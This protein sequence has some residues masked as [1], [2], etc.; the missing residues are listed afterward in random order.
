LKPKVWFPEHA[1]S[2][3]IAKWT[4]NLATRTDKEKY[5]CKYYESSSAE[6]PCRRL[7][8]FN[9]LR[10]DFLYGPRFRPVIQKS[11]SVAHPLMAA[12]SR[13]TMFRVTSIEKVC[14]I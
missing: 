6:E 9:G 2:E 7:D 8:A 11:N 14:A 4:L 5:F 10:P 1:S 12:A 3:A 13:T